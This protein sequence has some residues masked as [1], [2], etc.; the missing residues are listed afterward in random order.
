MDPEDEEEMQ[1]AAIREEGLR[2][3]TAVYGLPA[4]EFSMEKIMGE[5]SKMLPHIAILRR[6]PMSIRPLA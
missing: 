4:A 1:Q 6:S 5:M 3:W 2:E